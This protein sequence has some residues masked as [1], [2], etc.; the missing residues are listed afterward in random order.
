MRHLFLSACVLAI[1]LSVQPSTSFAADLPKCR[2]IAGY[3]PKNAC[4]ARNQRAQWQAEE[5]ARLTAKLTAEALAAQAAAEGGFV[6]SAK[7]FM[8]DTVD[9]IKSFF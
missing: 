1:C 2:N 3:E 8:G 6:N 9:K 4:E 5:T 7:Q